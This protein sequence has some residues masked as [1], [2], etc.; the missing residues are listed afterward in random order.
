VSHRRP[1]AVLF[2]LVILACSGSVALA[3]EP[4]TTSGSPAPLLWAGRVVDRHGQAAPAL[5]SAFIRPPASAIPSA[6]E[7]TAAPA[8]IPLTSGQTGQD[9]RFE[10]RVES[11]AV[12]AE[13]RPDGWLH[14]MLFTEGADGS[15][16]IATD[17]V[18]YVPAGGGLAR[19]AW[20]STLAAQERAE[21]LRTSGGSRTR[22]M[23]AMDRLE[24]EDQAGGDERPAVIQLGEPKAQASAAQPYGWKGPGEPYVACTARHVEDRQKAMRTISD[25]DVGP[26]WSYAIDY[27]NTGTTSWDVGYEQSGGNWKVA[28]TSSF[29]D[30]H[31]T[32]FN[33]EYGPY[34]ARFR[35]TYQ[36]R[37][38]HAKV[39]W[40]CG[41]RTSPG[42]FYVRTV[43]PESWTGGTFNEGEPVVPCNP[44]HK[45]PVAG[46]TYGW[47]YEGKS[48][49]YSASA[50]VYGF[51]GQAAVSYSRSTRLGWRNH[52][53]HARHVC[54]ESGHP[55]TGRTRV[56]AMD[57]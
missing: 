46:R 29:S 23:A 3:A 24:A 2:A 25:I 38:V 44:R 48:S 26:H 54:G 45:E 43:E 19:P 50:A 18:R 21:Q 13:Y 33:A 57:E 39:L 14:V 4:E 35:E 53:E 16:S 5:V 7:A 20:L 31:S 28:G 32:G 27:T 12:P 51:S 37:L 30:S 47:R 22:T 1:L 55:Y 11:P 17:S 42:P 9:G 8:S 15:W 49:K 56:A 52:L 6:G 41:S 36:V 10:L 40:Q 34:P